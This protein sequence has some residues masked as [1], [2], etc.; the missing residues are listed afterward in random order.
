VKVHVGGKSSYGAA[1]ARSLRHGHGHAA[2]AITLFGL[3]TI[4]NEFVGEMEDEFIARIYMPCR[5][6]HYF[7]WRLI[8]QTI[9]Q[10]AAAVDR[11]LQRQTY[12]QLTVCG[13]QAERIL[14]YASLC[15]T[16]RTVGL[17]HYGTYSYGEQVS[18][19]QKLQICTHVIYNLRHTLCHNSII[20]PREPAIH[21]HFDL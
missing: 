14:Y 6:F 7:V 5:R 17:S 3:Q 18:H 2:H 13:S 12:G 9:V 11:V 8:I 20:A 4:R 16:R 15:R 1:L 21:Y 10:V 19:S